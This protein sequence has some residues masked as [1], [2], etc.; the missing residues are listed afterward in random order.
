MKTTHKTFRW[1]LWPPHDNV[2]GASDEFIAKGFRVGLMGSALEVSFEDSGTCSPVSAR[3]LAEKYVETLAK[4]LATTLTLMTEDDW[5]LRT[6]PPLGRMMTLNIQRQDRGR[7]VRAV[8]NA[9]NELLA[10]EDRTLRKCYDYLQD[11]LERVPPGNDE[12]A[13]DAYKASEV[14]EER[15]GGEKKAV[16]ALG[17]ILKK[18]G[19]PPL[20]RTLC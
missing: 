15:F 9:R 7:A 18:A 10:S 13:Y 5:V 6:T 8:R 4:H 1:M 3:S 11:A 19:I 20:L 16:A 2:R 17:T 12:A 14:L